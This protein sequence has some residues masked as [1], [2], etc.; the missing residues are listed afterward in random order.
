M[1]F[2]HLSYLQRKRRLPRISSF[3]F[4]PHDLQTS[5]FLSE[6]ILTSLAFISR[7]RCFF[8]SRLVFPAVCDPC[9]GSGLHSTNHYLP[10]SGLYLRILY[11][12]S[13]LSLYPYLLIS[14]LPRLLFSLLPSLI[15]NKTKVLHSEESTLT[16][17]MSPSPSL[18]LTTTVQDIPKCYFTDCQIQ[19]TLLLD[20]MLLDLL[21]LQILFEDFS[22]TSS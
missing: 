10:H 12:L 3:N 19:R 17:F 13:S 21:K 20:F 11:G 6:S 4:Q 15:V 1:T 7:K 8:S 16:V 22:L 9:F 18:Q 14:P 5:L 2:P